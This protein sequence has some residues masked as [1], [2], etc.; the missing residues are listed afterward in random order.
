MRPSLVDDD[1]H[2][3]MVQIRRGRRLLLLY[4]CRLRRSTKAEL[5]LQVAC[6]VLPGVVCGGSDVHFSS[7]PVLNTVKICKLP[8]AVDKNQLAE[9]YI[10]NF[11]CRRQKSLCYYVSFLMTF[12][13]TYYF[14][15]I[16]FM[17]RRAPFSFFLPL[18]LDNLE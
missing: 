18:P 2:E 3:S 4:Q 14:S 12:F 5:L 1:D 16:C 13:D 15:A 17:P 6:L 9:I 11:C 10:A 8:T 7:R